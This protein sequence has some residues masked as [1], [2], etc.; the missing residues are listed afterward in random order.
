MR[1]RPKPVRAQPGTVPETI[2]ND[3]RRIIID[4]SPSNPRHYERMSELLDALVRQRRTVH[5][6]EYLADDRVHP[7]GRQRRGG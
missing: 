5:Y 2:E 1:P 6:T 7:Q 4:R 3:V